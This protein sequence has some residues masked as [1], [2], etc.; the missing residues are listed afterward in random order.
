[1]KIAS[2]IILTLTTEDAYVTFEL[3]NVK[4]RYENGFL[5]VCSDT[6]AFGIRVIDYTES[7]GEITI[8]TQ[9]GTLQ[10]TPVKTEN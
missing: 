4:T 6:G 2:N 9:K 5:E 7:D 1:M 8:M 10:I 3:H